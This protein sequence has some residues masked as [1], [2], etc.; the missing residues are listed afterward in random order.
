MTGVQTCA[1]PISIDLY[2][3]YTGT[4]LTA[5]L[6]QQA[7]KDAKA[8][9]ERVREGYR[10]WGIEWLPPLGFNNSFAMVVRA[11]SAREKACELS[12]RRRGAPGRGTLAW[13]MSSPSGPTA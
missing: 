3:E 12:A 11:E 8:A 4:A 6:K 7:V 13:D 9:L 1:L 5:V 10:P 2:P